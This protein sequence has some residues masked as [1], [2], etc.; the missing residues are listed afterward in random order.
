MNLRRI[1]TFLVLALAAVALAWAGLLGLSRPATGDKQAGNDRRFDLPLGE[2]RARAPSVVDYARLDSRLQRLMED[3][4]MV[5]LAVAVVEDGEIRF[6]KGYGETVAGSGQPVTTATVFRWASLSKGVAGDMVALLAD[7]QKLSLYEPVSRY[8]PSLRLPGG[9]ENRATVSDLLSHRLGLF[10]H[11]QDPKLEEGWDP[12]YL[13]GTLATLHNIC[14]PGTC[15]AYQNVAYD[16][17]SEIVERVTG[18][19]YREAVRERLFAPLG[20]TSASLTRAELFAAPSWARPHV[21]GRNSR[22]VEV[23]E[24]YY[25]VPA[26]GGVNGSIEDLAAWML[27]QMG[28]AED[29]LP[30]RVLEAVQTPRAATPREVARRRKYRERTTTAAYGL[31]W[32]ILDYSGHRVI[33]HHGGVRGYRSMILFDPVR[34]AGVV[35]L[36]NSATSRPNGIE[37]E[38]MD[39]VYRLP[40]RDWLAIEERSLDAHPPPL[41]ADE[42]LAEGAGTR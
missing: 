28:E 38:V 35:A 24:P 42:E 18:Q 4:A 26:A 9:N 14:A 22:P 7:E 15:H 41:P 17:A 16:A 2:E 34:R 27:A 31:G 8:A 40:F 1:V 25:R 12:R 23:T 3:P 19:P 37:Y 13:R 20:M 36:W 29:V 6:A 39:M 33:G 32:R 5:G 11:A 30:R 21:G 10:G